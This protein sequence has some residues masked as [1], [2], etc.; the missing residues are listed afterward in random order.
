MEHTWQSAHLPRLE[1]SDPE[2]GDVV[3][4]AAPGGA[5]LLPALGAERVAF[6]APLGSRAD[7]EWLL[8]GLLH[9]PNV[10]HLVVCGDD[11]KAS[12]EALLSLWK[13]GLDA[14]ARI[15]GSRGHLAPDL[16]ASRIDAL[17]REV[18]AVDLRDRPLEEVARALR[19]LPALGTA[20][21]PVPVPPLAP[22]QRRVFL[23][24]RTSFPV[25][26]SDVA[27]SWLQLLNLTLRIGLDKPAAGGG[28]CAEALNVLVT[29]ES[30]VLED[31]EAE[32]P[33]PF[34][35]FL[36]FSRDDFERRFQPAHAARLRERLGGDPLELA[37]ERLEQAPEAGSV[38]LAL[39]DAPGAGA[40]DELMSVG[41]DVVEGKLFASFVLRSSDVYTDWPL[42]ASA[43]R[44]LQEELAGRLGLGVGSTSFVVHRARLHEYDFERSSRV[45]RESFKR[46][47]PLHVDPSGVFLFGNDGGKARGML[48]NHDASEI[49]W[50]DAFSSPEDLSWYIVDV[51]PWLLPQHIRYVGQ[52]CASLMRAMKEGECYLQG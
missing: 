17:R 27:D 30:P 3:V 38:T 29:I 23:S 42:E 10:R 31:G 39:A 36:D 50:E 20:G 32:P 12:G 47:L 33:E 25:F 18:Q 14:E 52:E 8:R 13:E 11:A 46:P 5:P 4:C 6:V 22:S 7:L 45:L 41:F 34:P 16:D 15:A 37:R 28:H 35:A 21:E 19:E 48:L 9:H 24:R 26:S 51:M 43:L 1:L 2:R 44:R 40:G 49:F